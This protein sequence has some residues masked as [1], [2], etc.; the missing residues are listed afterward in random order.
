[1]TANLTLLK[2][3]TD[4]KIVDFTEANGLRICT[5]SLEELLAFGHWLINRVAGYYAAALIHCSTGCLV[6]KQFGACKETEVLAE[7]RF[8]VAGSIFV[9][10]A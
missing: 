3:K 5:E 4:Q 6:A 1:M 10:D 9:A 2:A 8:L 7:P